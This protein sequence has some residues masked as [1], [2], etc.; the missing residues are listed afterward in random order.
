MSGSSNEDPARLEKVPEVS[1]VLP[2]VGL[3]PALTWRADGM[4]SQVPRPPAPRPSTTRQG[5]QWKPVLQCAAGFLAFVIIVVVY[6]WLVP[7]W[8]AAL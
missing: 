1:E 4:G 3:P 7:G 2:G 8:W 6:T 5:V